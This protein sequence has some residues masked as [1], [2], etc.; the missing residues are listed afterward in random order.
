MKKKI[1]I[2][3]DGE[4]NFALNVITCLSKR[5][6][7]DVY[8]LSSLKYPAIR[9]SRYCKF[10]FYKKNETDCLACIK[11]IASKNRSAVLIPVT[12]KGIQ[13]IIQNKN[14]LEKLELIISI[15]DEDSFQIASDKALF[16]EFNWKNKIPHPKTVLLEREKATNLEDTFFPVLIKPTQGSGGEGIRLYNTKAELLQEIDSYSNSAKR[17]VIQQYI[18]GYDIDCSVLCRHGEILAY[19]IQRG[20][21]KK[22]RFL[23]ASSV[24]FLFNQDLLDVVKGLMYKLNWT[25]IAHIDLL[26]D[27]K[28]KQIKVIEINPRYWASLLGSLS[29][30]VNFPYFNLLSSQ[31]RFFKI[32]QY[33]YK[34]YMS[35]TA[36]F[37]S[38]FQRKD[39]S[40]SEFVVNSFYYIKRDPLPSVISKFNFI[41]NRLKKRIIKIPYL[42]SSN[43]LHK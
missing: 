30:G 38:F 9:F 34:Y 23:P 5:V 37:R 22:S 14:T 39:D 8:I 18:Y 6:D 3:P 1:V 15:P 28:E 13:F 26:F 11:E 21:I 27:E 20:V 24:Q 16:A 4:N 29:V 12:E 32:P 35:V 19:T 36:Y 33:D 31:N 41:C 42:Y 40:L 10:F 25:G 43:N 17:Y 2:I 7:L